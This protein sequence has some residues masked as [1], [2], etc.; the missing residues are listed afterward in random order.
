MDPH[1]LTALSE[2]L[3]SRLHECI[4]ERARELIRRAAEEG[5]A[6]VV[7]QGLRTFAEQQALYDQGRTKP[8]KIVTN[9]PPGSS[10]HN[11][12]LAFD[13]AELVAGK[14]HYPSDLAWWTH[15]GEL[16]KALELDWGGDFHTFVD[17]PHFE[18]HPHLRLAD[19]RAG[20]LP[21]DAVT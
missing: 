21:P 16:G 6:L 10:W 2:H 3:I 14:Y 20:H 18:Y 9:A 11:F 17:R 13:V 19:A 7:T 4:Q 15:I 12:G 8:G 5:I 1:A